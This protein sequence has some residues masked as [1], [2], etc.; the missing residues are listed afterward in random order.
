MVEGVDMPRKRPAMV[1][2]TRL[3]LAPAMPSWWR[4]RL[5]EDVILSMPYR[6]R[7]SAGSWA[8]SK[9]RYSMVGAAGFV[10]FFC[11]ALAALLDRTAVHCSC[12]GAAAAV[13]YDLLGR[14]GLY[15]VCVGVCKKRS[16][17]SRGSTTSLIRRPTLH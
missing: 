3:T 7:I 8:S 5:I 1:C 9:L 11:R 17:A 15:C 4:V 12:S 6:L 14:G 13:A 16:W 2:L 10:C